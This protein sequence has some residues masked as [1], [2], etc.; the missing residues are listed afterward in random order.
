MT[1]MKR[2]GAI[3]AFTSV[4]TVAA[5][6][7]S[8]Y[9]QNMVNTGRAAA[10]NGTVKITNYAGAVRVE[11]WDRDSV[12]V[13]GTLA[14][15][16][17]RVDLTGD[18]RSTRVR[19]VIRREQRQETA[20]SGSDL[21]VRV[22]ASSHLAVRTAGG[23]IE[24]HEVHGAVDLETVDGGVIVA[25]SGLRSIHAFAG[26]DVII[27]AATKILRARSFGGSVTVQH[28]MGYVDVSTVAGRI[29]LNGRN[30]WEGRASSVSGDIRFN[31]DFDANGSFSFE[32]NSGDIELDL[33]RSA[34]ADFEV[35]T[36][37][38]R[39]ENDLALEAEPEEHIAG[40]R[41]EVMFAIGDAGSRIKI[42][43]YKGNVRLR[44]RP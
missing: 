2:I 36:Y 13:T 40:R 19:V 6:P 14:P 31:G 22:P 42:Q 39:L 4:L 28:A 43:T 11:G 5:G 17:E 20:P 35:V 12:A 16:V 32:S 15:S 7:A 18:A 33:P 34:N 9:A 30:V 26:G 1:R 8:A 23:S 29:D 44:Q 21:V 37:G 10:K 25:G 3:V 24:V 41:R 27:E 38:G